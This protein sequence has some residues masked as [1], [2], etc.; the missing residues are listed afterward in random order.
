[1]YTYNNMGKKVQYTSINDTHPE[2]IPGKASFQLCKKLPLW[3][4]ITMSV[5]TVI[6]IIALLILFF[7]K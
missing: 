1:M 2:Q 5:L 7:M 6:V 3:A 4:I